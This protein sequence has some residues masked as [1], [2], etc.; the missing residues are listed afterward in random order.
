MTYNV[1]SHRPASL[2]AT[3]IG[4]LAHPVKG[5][6]LNG[7]CPDNQKCSLAI[8]CCD[9]CWRMEPELIEAARV[10]GARAE[11]EALYLRPIKGSAGVRTLKVLEQE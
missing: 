2:N 5:N 11:A 9:L 10:A 3:H 1:R 6:R 4:D 7:Q 8:H